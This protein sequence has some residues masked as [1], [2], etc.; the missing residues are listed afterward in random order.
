MSDVSSI[1]NA[2]ILPKR[3]RDELQDTFKNGRI[4]G[5]AIIEEDRA[6]IEFAYGL[7]SNKLEKNGND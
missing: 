4:I 1:C 6:E 5:K 2:E 7:S 3:L